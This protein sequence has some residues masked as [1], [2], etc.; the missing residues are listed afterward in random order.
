[1]SISAGFIQSMT[2]E[3]GILEYEDFPKTESP[4]WI[5]GKTYSTLYGMYMSVVHTP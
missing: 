1:V 4:V 2:Y 3:T 5:L